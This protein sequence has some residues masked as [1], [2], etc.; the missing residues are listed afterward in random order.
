MSDTTDTGGMAAS[1]YALHP[2]EGETVINVTGKAVM[3][4]GVEVVT[5][6]PC[7]KCGHGTGQ[8][9]ALEGEGM[10][11]CPCGVILKVSKGG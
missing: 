6:P 5:L 8:R 11:R 1:P 9:R 4:C 3:Q 2:M 7:P 10:I